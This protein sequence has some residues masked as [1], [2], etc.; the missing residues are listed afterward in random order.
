MVVR[1]GRFGRSRLV[2]L[3]DA[4]GN[5]AEIQ[6]SGDG[7]IPGNWRHNLQGQG[8]CEQENVKPYAAHQLFPE[9]TEIHDNSPKAKF[10]TSGKEKYST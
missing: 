1:E 6:S 2:R 4:D 3:A 10:H 7:Q 8:Q 5:A 9:V